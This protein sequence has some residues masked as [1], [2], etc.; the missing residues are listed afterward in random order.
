VILKDR[1]RDDAPEL[2]SYFTRAGIP[3]LLLS[4]DRQESARQAAAG[5]GIGA[6]I[7]GL[8]PAQKASRIEFLRQEA[9]SRCNGSSTDNDEAIVG[10]DVPIRTT[11]TDPKPTFHLCSKKAT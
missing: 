11:A 4:G 3:T 7:G 10:V 2:V 6:G 5:I 9:S 1:M 8:S